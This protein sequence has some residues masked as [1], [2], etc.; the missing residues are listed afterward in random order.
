MRKF[1]IFA[2]LMVIATAYSS[3][4]A[5]QILGLSTKFSNSFV[6]WVVYTDDENLDGTLALRWANLNDWSGWDFRVGEL[7]GSVDQVIKDDFNRYNMRANNKIITIQTI[8]QNDFFHWQITTPEGIILQLTC[9][10]P[11]NPQEWELHSDT[12]GLFRIYT[13]WEN[14]FREW[15]VEDNLVPEIDQY[16]KLALMFAAVV[17]ATP[18]Q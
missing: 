12:Y 18:K 6:D 13:A 1:L 3:L 16:T 4:K 15:A 2:I 9:E 11:T 10:N 7:Y 14:D 17:S 5:Q 8:W